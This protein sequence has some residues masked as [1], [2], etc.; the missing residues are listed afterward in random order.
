[1]TSLLFSGAE[2]ICSECSK[3][4]TSS[5][6]RPAKGVVGGGP[7]W[8]FCPPH[9]CFELVALQKN[10]VRGVGGRH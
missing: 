9:I 1:M 7:F 10:Y 2:T 6:V 3:T 5:L 8:E 4:S